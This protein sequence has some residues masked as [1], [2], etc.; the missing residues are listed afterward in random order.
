VEDALSKATDPSHP[1]ASQKSGLAPAT[2]TMAW[3]IGGLLFLATVLNYM[4][5]QTLSM[6]A[7]LIQ[8]ELALDNAQFGLLASA[9]FFT[10]GIMM[11]IAGWIMDRVNIRWGYAATVLVWS[12]AGT[13]TGAAANF[14]QLF[15][16]RLLLGIGEAANWPAALRVISR[17]TPVEKRSLMN[18]FFNSGASVG[19]VITPPLMVYLSMRAGWR[20]AFVVIGLFGFVWVCA[21]LLITRWVPQIE[22]AAEPAADEAAVS[23][24]Q[25]YTLSTWREILRAGRFWGLI[26][27]AV[28]YN[29]CY[30]FYSTWLPTYFVQQ[31]G[32]PFGTELGRIMMVPYIGFGIG[33]MLGGVPA[34]WLSRRGWPVRRS[35]KLIASVATVLMLPIVAVPHVKSMPAALAIIF[36]MAVS[37]GAWI[38]HYLSAL[39]DVSER[40]VSSVSGLIGAF[41]A[42]AGALGMWGVGIVTSHAGGFVPV[43][44]ALGIMPIAATL[45]IVVPRWP[46]ASTR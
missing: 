10:Y 34:I 39:Q 41:G 8:K 30:Y 23:S 31:R 3:V 2:A 7:P 29:P 25:S 35:R 13:L 18:G 14:T 46:Y 42:F 15:S 45:G 5:R 21:W 27:S 4:D 43:F 44:I 11:G 1:A 40:Q 32:I 36:M 6:A 9:F 24:D 17:V 37:L 38:A 28:T 19:A 12:L 20:F 33:S 22:K 16:C 26:V